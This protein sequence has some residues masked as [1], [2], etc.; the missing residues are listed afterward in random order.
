MSQITSGQYNYAFGKN[1][2]RKVTTGSHNLGIG[3]GAGIEINTGTNNLILGQGAGDLITG[4][5]YNICIGYEAGDVLTTG[6]NNIVIGKGADASSA[7]TSNEITLGNDSITKFRIPGINVVLKDNG[8]TPTQGHVLVVDSNGEASFESGATG[9]QGAQGAQGVQGATNNLSISTSPPGSPNAGDMWWDSDGGILA[10]YYDD[11][12]GSPSAQWVEIAAG[13]NGNQGTQGVQ[14]AQGATGS[15]GPQGVQGAQGGDGYW[16]GNSAGIHTMSSVGIGTTTPAG[17]QNPNPL[18][19]TKLDV[20]KSF[21]GGGD[22]AFVG[23]FYG[24]DTN[25]EETSVRFV[26]KGT[27][28]NAADLHNASD[29][30]LMHGISNGTTKFVFGANGNVGIG[31]TLPKAKLDVNG[32]LNVSGVSTFEDGLTIGGPFAGNDGVVIKAPNSGSRQILKLFGGGV[33]DGKV[34]IQ[35]HGPNNNNL[36]ANAGGSTELWWAATG[37]TAKK[38]ET[39]GY[40]VSVYGSIAIGSSIYD[41]NGIFGSN[42][43]VLSSVPGIGVSWTTAIGFATDK[44]SEGDSK[45]EII[46]NVSE[47]KFTVHIDNAEKLSVD[48]G[49]TKIHRQDSSDEGG[50]VVFNRAN[51]DN[52]A[53]EIDVLGSSNTDPGRL[54]ILDQSGPTGVERFAI[55]PAGQIG[56]GGANYGDSGQVLTSNGSSSAP[57]WQTVSG[58]TGPQ[59]AQGDDGATGPTGPQGATGSTGSI[60]TGII[61]MWSGAANAIPTGYALC[62]GTNSTPDL[63]DRFI[64]GAGN[65]YNV[66]AQGG[67]ANAVLIA[68]SHTYDRATQ[69]NVADGGVNGAYVSSLTGDTTDITGVDNAGNS[70]T[71]QTGTNANLPPYYA[72]CYIMKT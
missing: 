63:R 61:V 6:D 29:A 49:G 10:V 31:S 21:V 41:S 9:P 4:G 18:F 47:S 12:S 27:G 34:V 24:L 23:R 65:N 36:V 25:V 45:A 50:S 55:G 33:T 67:S 69:R 14:G 28:G 48:I 59:G 70:S 57:T 54:R 35:G 15:T 13:P 3:Y 19:A 43:Q 11:G 72:L 42:G 22:G 46:D 60:P 39:T 17:G 52:A 5:G 40:G 71:S 2:L 7:T 58:G 44:I 20:F 30:Y 38:L 1:A 64:V 26:T 68:H 37:N 62:D 66:G 53:F 8:G 56:L 51:D 16:V 32:T